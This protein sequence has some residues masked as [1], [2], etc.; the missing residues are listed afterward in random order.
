KD[1]YNATAAAAEYDLGNFTV[2]TGGNYALRFT[3]VGK[4]AAATDWKMAFDFIKLIPQKASSFRS[5]Y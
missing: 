1:E 4:N 5:R 3:V 2:S